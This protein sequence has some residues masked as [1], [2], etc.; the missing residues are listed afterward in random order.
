MFMLL[1]HWTLRVLT[2]IAFLAVLVF[3]LA[4]IFTSRDTGY[5]L[6]ATSEIVSILLHD[7]A[8]EKVR[9]PEVR[10]SRD[11][12]YRSA[13]LRLLD[14]VSIRMQRLQKGDVRMNLD[15][16]ESSD[17]ARLITAE[18]EAIALTRQET[19]VIPMNQGVLTMAFRGTLR[20]GQQTAREI[21]GVLLKGRIAIFQQPPGMRVR[22]AISDSPLD[23]GDLPLWQKSTGE[24]V[25]VAG[26]VHANE[27]EALQ[28][29]AHG[30]ADHVTVQRY[31]GREYV[32]SPTPWDRFSHDP[33]LS[34]STALFALLSG[35]FV[36]YEM[37]PR[38]NEL[39]QR[40]RKK[41]VPRV[42]DDTGRE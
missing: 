6:S 24:D 10:L 25:E 20:L 16:P 27:E 42:D 1:F 11:R 29:V 13:S 34:S 38:M 36:L 5:S 33:Y 21:E 12:V 35:F 7:Q 3:A 30:D 39:R 14:G 40:N 15:W 23:A 2:P 18:G 28:V 41:P 4:Q 22:Y 31:G 8:G 17:G 32:I 19:L 37:F 26:F 9:L